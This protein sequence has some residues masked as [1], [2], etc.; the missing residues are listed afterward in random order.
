MLPQTFLYLFKEDI[1]L[2]GKHKM[3]LPHL[4]AAPTKWSVLREWS[5]ILKIVGKLCLSKGSIR[6]ALNAQKTDA[7]NFAK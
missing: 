6:N 4:C 1:R 2:S 7:K 3:H 5:R